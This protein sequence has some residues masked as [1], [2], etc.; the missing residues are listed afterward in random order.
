MYMTQ[1][2][3]LVDIMKRLRGP[4]GCP[5]DKEQTHATLKAYLIEEAYEVIDAIDGK[6]DSDILEELGDVLLQVVFHAQIGAEENRFTIE[7]V[8]QSIADKLVRRHPHVFGDV[9]VETSDQVVEN[10]EAIKSQEKQTKKIDESALSGVPRHL[11]ALLR[12][13]SF[14]KK[15]ARVGFDWEKVEEVAQKVEEEW[16]ELQNARTQEEKQEEFGDLLFSLV[17]LARFLKIDPEEALSQTIAKFQSRFAFIESELKKRGKSAQ[18]ATL[19][20]M[21][22]LW[23]SAKKTP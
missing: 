16:G 22:A 3:R 17:N 11:P 9:A 23:E 19:A 10:W 12:A 20:E 2:D 13:Q 7:D 4:D 15:A 1:F 5:W 18:D 8:G 14:Q 21:D 6:T